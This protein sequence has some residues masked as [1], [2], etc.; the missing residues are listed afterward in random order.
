MTPPQALG[1]LHAW[2]YDEK[3]ALGPYR[4]RRQ[5]TSSANAR[6]GYKPGDENEEGL[7]P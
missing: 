6:A 5:E 4:T 2:P 3:R 1:P 7:Q